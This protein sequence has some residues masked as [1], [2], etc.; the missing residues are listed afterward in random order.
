MAGAP[1]KS[2]TEIHLHHE[3]VRLRPRFGEMKRRAARPCSKCVG[4]KTIYWNECDHPE[5][6]QRPR[7]AHMKKSQQRHVEFPEPSICKRRKHK[8]IKSENQ[9]HSEED[10]EQ[11]MQNK[12]KTFTL[13]KSN[14]NNGFAQFNWKTIRFIYPLY[15]EL[16]TTK[17][18][19]DIWTKEIDTKK[20][21]RKTMKN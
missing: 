14:Y 2:T 8:S 13:S 9:S 20:N 7:E 5:N 18:V 11:K 4:R 1:S 15:C 19:W 17:V 16:V 6:Q 12:K 3:S 10:E 21:P